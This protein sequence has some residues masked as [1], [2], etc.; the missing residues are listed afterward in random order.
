MLVFLYHVLLYSPFVRQVN[1]RE[2]L[3]VVYAFYYRFHSARKLIC[4]SEKK[5][6]CNRHRLS[7][8]FCLTNYIRTTVIGLILIRNFHYPIL[9]F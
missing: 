4:L 3:V 1:L 2:M 8:L 7:I 6:D 9:D 5:F